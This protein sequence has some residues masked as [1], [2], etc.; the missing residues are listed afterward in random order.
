MSVKSREDIDHLTA[1]WKY[2]SFIA[3]SLAP[4]LQQISKRNDWNVFH[5]TE[6]NISGKAPLVPKDFFF[7]WNKILGLVS[8]C[9]RIVP[10]NMLYWLWWNY[11]DQTNLRPGVISQSLIITVKTFLE[12]ILRHMS[13]SLLR[14]GKKLYNYVIFVIFRS[15]TG[16]L[17]WDSNYCDISPDCELEN[18]FIKTVYFYCTLRAANEQCV[19][20]SDIFLI[21]MKNVIHVI[22]I[23]LL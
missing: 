23:Y 6:K 11:S 8:F 9:W 5:M 21:T 18:S 12:F 14:D 16:F 2:F 17:Q 20:C 1:W 19:C 3:P 22:E 13:S 4:M 10:G 15:R 7:S